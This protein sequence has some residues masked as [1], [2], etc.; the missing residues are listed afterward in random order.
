MTNKSPR[1]THQGYK[2]KYYD[3]D[4]QDEIMEEVAANLQCDIASVEAVISNHK[5]TYIVKTNDEDIPIEY[6]AVKISPSSYTY[7]AKAMIYPWQ[8]KEYKMLYP[9]LFRFITNPNNEVWEVGVG[10]VIERFIRSFNKLI[11][12]IKKIAREE[13]TEQF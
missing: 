4:E 9:R 10:D 1:V 8:D 7:E 6:F 5:L 2:G 13:Q 11:R 12:S 3:I